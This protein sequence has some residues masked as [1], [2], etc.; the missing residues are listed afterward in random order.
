[1]YIWRDLSANAVRRRWH[2]SAM[3]PATCQISVTLMPVRGA[4]LTETGPVSP[5]VPIEPSFHVLV[6]VPTAPS[7]FN[8]DRTRSTAAYNRRSYTS[9]SSTS[10]HSLFQLPPYP[11]ARSIQ[12]H[13][14]RTRQTRAES[15]L[16]H[17]RMRKSTVEIVAVLF[18]F[19][20]PKP[21]RVPFLPQPISPVI[22]HAMP[23]PQV[24]E[25]HRFG[26]PID[27]M[28]DKNRHELASDICLP[29]GEKHENP[30]R[31]HPT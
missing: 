23:C 31:L 8:K 28:C 13:P 29:V 11:L 21:P 19:P 7:F 22:G 27:E 10:S 5:A 24:G 20:I 9:T 18:A 12:L 30:P 14:P 1:M 16:F 4:S 6:P 2:A 25:I 15:P 17:P 3:Q 26:D